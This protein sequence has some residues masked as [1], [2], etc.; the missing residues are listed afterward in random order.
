VPADGWLGPD[1]V[2][3]LLR[4]WDLPVA[5]WRIVADAAALADALALLGLPCVM[6]AIRP[7]L[8]HKTE[9]GAVRLGLRDLAAA[10]EA[11]DDFARRLGPGPVLVQAQARPGV[12]LM[13]GAVRDPT[14]GPLVMF[15]LG[16]IWAEALHDVAIRQAPVGAAEVLRALDELRGRALL[17]G[18]RGAPAV[19]TAAL[20][21]LVATF[22]AAVAR[23]PWC[24]ELDLN[25]VLAS[26]QQLVI[27]DARLRVQAARP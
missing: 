4:A 12:E 6:K 1:Q 18:L 5:P 24:A 27:V 7:G 8:V 14:F 9:A 21:R 16:G 13:L 20:A 26:A 19:D 11:F 23:A 3:D 25:P 15:G 22:A 17:G 10:R 2:F